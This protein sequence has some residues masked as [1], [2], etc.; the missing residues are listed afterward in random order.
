MSSLI[1]ID[2]ANPT[3]PACFGVCCPRHAACAR[4]AAADGP[5][6][7]QGGAPCDDA[8][9]GERPLFMAALANEP[10]ASATP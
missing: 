5:A 4:Y 2:R 7:Q 1:V 9:N 8:G 3:A 10:A 6:G